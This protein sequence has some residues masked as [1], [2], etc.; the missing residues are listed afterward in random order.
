MT[1]E[2][3]YYKTL[4]LGESASAEEIKKAYY[5]LAKELHPDI[6]VADEVRMKEVNEAHDILS[7]EN[8][9]KAYDKK[10]LA[11]ERTDTNAAAVARERADKARAARKRRQRSTAEAKA[12]GDHIRGQSTARAQPK[13]P[14]PRSTTGTHR[15]PVMPASA[16]PPLISSDDEL[17]TAEV[18]PP[19]KPPHDLTVV[20]CICTVVIVAL[21]L[22]FNNSTGP[23]TGGTGTEA[24]TVNP[25]QTPSEN[26]PRSMLPCE[27]ATPT[28]GAVAALAC[29][30]GNSKTMVEFY[31]TDAQAIAHIEAEARTVNA[32]TSGVCPGDAPVILTYHDTETPNVPAGKVLCYVNYGRAVYSWTS[33]G[34]RRYNQMTMADANLQAAQEEWD[35]S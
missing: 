29:A 22:L 10:R 30:P 19:S 14:P 31:N 25:S 32:A 34:D 11:Q 15:P 18:N 4:G 28:A 21:A 26:V 1:R 35:G 9:K 17:P 2:K 5:K 24:S 6:N 12:F 23:S 33:F 3:Q 13:P 16:R 20:L 27:H 8:K 7:D